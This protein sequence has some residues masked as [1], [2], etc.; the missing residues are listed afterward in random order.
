MVHFQLGFFLL[1]CMPQKYFCFRCS[2]VTKKCNGGYLMSSFG[3]RSFDHG[4]TT[5]LRTC[6]GRHG[7]RFVSANLWCSKSRAR[8][9]QKGLNALVCFEFYRWFHSLW[10][11]SLTRTPSPWQLQGILESK[12]ALWRGVFKC[13]ALDSG[14]SRESP[15]V[16]LSV[17]RSVCLFGLNSFGGWLC[18]ML[19]GTWKT[20]NSCKE[21]MLWWGWAVRSPVVNCGWHVRKSSA[22]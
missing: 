1:L 13:S 5:R 22:Q 14:W 15:S 18:A 21:W 3:W 6:S 16:C 17:G 4:C 2:N 11:C 19:A 9:D 12:S 20:A 7:L 8:A 10:I